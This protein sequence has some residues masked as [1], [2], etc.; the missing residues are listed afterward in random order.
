MAGG[1]MCLIQALRRAGG[2]GA[3][4]EPAVNVVLFAVALK[5]LNRK[6]LEVGNY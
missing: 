5:M 2:Q 1:M 3:G 6:G 4:H